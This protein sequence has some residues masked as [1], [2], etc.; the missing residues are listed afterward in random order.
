MRLKTDF[1]TNSSSTSFIVADYRKEEGKIP[2][3]ISI[4]VNLMDHETEVF[5]TEEQV[6]KYFGDD[7]GSDNFIK[8]YLEVIRKGGKVRIFSVS[9]DGEPVEEFLQD[10]GITQEDMPEGVEVIHGD[11]GY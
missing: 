7:W 3:E 11:G 10:R 5:T 6:K 8:S 9:N 4:K 1:V 2:L